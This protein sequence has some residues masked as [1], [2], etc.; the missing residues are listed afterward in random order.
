MDLF[1]VYAGQT[2]RNREADRTVCY[3]AARKAASR[4]IRK[5]AVQ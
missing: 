1:E 2:G 3:A 4:R 5:A